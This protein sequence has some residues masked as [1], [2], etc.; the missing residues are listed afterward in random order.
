MN[1]QWFTSSICWFTAIFIALKSAR[2]SLTYMT[3]YDYFFCLC[4][5]FVRFSIVFIFRKL[6]TMFFG[7]TFMLLGPL[8]YMTF[9]NTWTYPYFALVMTFAWRNEFF[10]VS[11]KYDSY[12]TTVWDDFMSMLWL[13][14]QLILFQ[15]FIFLICFNYSLVSIVE[16]LSKSSLK[17]LLLVGLKALK[18][19]AY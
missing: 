18:N 7:R 13:W 6:I 12:M 17:L 1:C 10:R 8:L 2:Y 19:E 3:C 14:H 15:L 5:I 9:L 16:C 11:V 4:F